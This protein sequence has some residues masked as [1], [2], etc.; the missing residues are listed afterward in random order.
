MDKVRT[1]CC[2]T[3]TRCPDGQCTLVY[4]FGGAGVCVH[5]KWSWEMM[6]GREATPLSV[7]DME[8]AHS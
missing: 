5:C 4:R 8:K 6:P 2:G 3:L 1:Q 7:E